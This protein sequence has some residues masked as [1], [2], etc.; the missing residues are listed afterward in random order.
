MSGGGSIHRHR[1]YSQRGQP[2]AGAGWRWVN[3]ATFGSV[4]RVVPFIRTGY[5]RYVAGG[6]LPMELWCDYPRQSIHFD[7]LREAP[8]LRQST[9]FFSLF[10]T[11]YRDR[12]VKNTVIRN[13]YVVE[14]DTSEQRWSPQNCQL[15]IVHCQFKKT[16][17]CPLSTVNFSRN[18][19]N[20]PPRVSQ[21]H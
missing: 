10:G 15:S 20:S 1:L 12:Y 19:S 21:W 5:I 13:K 11:Q 6:R 17:N 2:L 18:V 3:A 14:M 4:Y 16:V 7:S 8:P 9:S